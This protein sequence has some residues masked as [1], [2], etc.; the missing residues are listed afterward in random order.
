MVDYSV[1]IDEELLK[2][3]RDG[4]SQA[5]EA[6]TDRYMQKAKAIASSLSVPS[7]E[8]QDY[9]Q[10]GMIGFLSAVSAYSAERAVSFGSFACACI[11]N[12]IISQLRKLSAGKNIP[13]AFIV[14]FEEQTQLLCSSLTPEEYLISEKNA[15]DI[16][17]A[18]S[19]L[20]LQE[21]ETFRLFLAGLS[22]EEIAG[23]LSL[24]AKAVDGS[25]QRARKKLRKT[26]SL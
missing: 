9:I 8:R 19:E 17:K 20:S 16:S 24:T 14:S 5:L 12:R 11:R 18:I 6:L 3:Y 4:D 1:L 26:L 23:E 22:Y 15:E 2:L 10:E 7:G 21:R 25:L 13:A